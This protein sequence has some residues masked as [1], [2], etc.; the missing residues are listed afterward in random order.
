MP[1]PDYI[2]LNKDQIVKVGV[3]AWRAAVA[4]RVGFM[5]DGAAYFTALDEALRQARRTIWIVGWDFNPDIYLRPDRPS[6]TLGELLRSLVEAN[7]DLEIRILV[8]AMG[9]I[10][11]GKS[12]ALFSE[13]S[14]SAHPR[15]HLRFDRRHA[16]R[17]SHHQ[18][19]VTIDDQLAFIGGID[20]THKRWDDPRH[21]PDNPLRVTPSGETYEPVHDLQA[22]LSGSAAAMIGDLARRRWRHA[23]GEDISPAPI[24]STDAVWPGSVSDDFGGCEVA[25]ARTEPGIRGRRSR[26]EAMRL[27]MDALASARDSIYIETQYLASFEVGRLLAKRLAE[28]D[29][30][31]VVVIVT[32]LSHGFLEKIMMGANRDRLIRRLKRADRHGRFRALYPVVPDHRGGECDILVH[33]KLVVVDDRFIRLGSSNLNN[34]SEGL[35]TESD[36]A[37]EAE[38]GACKGAI[39][40]LR[41]RLMAEHLDCSEQ[42]VRAAVT[43]RASLIGAIEELNT[44]PRGLRILAVDAEKG[45]TG[46]VFGTGMVDPRKP[47]TP[48]KGAR[49]LWDALMGRLTSL[50]A[51]QARKDM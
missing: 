42:D 36:I 48:I 17:G 22:A 15:I 9:P 16:I 46:P 44:K 47:F 45:Q 33:A 5:V 10:Y 51:P 1:N 50:V 14:W 39:L 26:R 19:F 23:N 7:G 12:L 34:R 3:N 4:E 28:P 49:R 27:T 37:I 2:S 11:S 18:K 24:E 8:W 35:D 30:P 29:G 25:L 40:S 6:E 38:N 32:R 31:E 21:D 41:D 20:L 13:N 43:R